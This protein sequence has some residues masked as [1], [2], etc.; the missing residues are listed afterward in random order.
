MKRPVR[1]DFIQGPFGSSDY[2]LNADKYM[3]YIESQLKK[4]REENTVN[5]MT[6][7]VLEFLI[8]RKKKA[9]CKHESMEKI[10]V[11]GGECDFCEECGIGVITL[12]CSS[13]TE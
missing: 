10:Q 4:E 12:D 3:D 11:D 13:E 9:N 5:K 2:R 7:N 6:I 1:E 8:D